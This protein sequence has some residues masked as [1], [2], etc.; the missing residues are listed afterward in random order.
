[1]L[2]WSEASYLPWNGDKILSIWQ[3]KAQILIY[4]CAV[5]GDHKQDFTNSYVKQ[6]LCSI[7][8]G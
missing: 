5:S 2:K 3:M 1:M 8:N 6:Y 7:I 4:V